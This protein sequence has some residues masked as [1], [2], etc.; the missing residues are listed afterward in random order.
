MWSIDDGDWT[1]LGFVLTL[2]DGRRVYLDYLF[3]FADDEE[4]IEVQPMGGERYPA[5]VGGGIE[6]S[7]DVGE[8]NQLLMS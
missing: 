4:E 2:Q 8:L 5:I 1:S 3:D 6:W 7:D